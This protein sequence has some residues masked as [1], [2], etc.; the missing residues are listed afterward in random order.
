MTEATIDIN[1]VQHEGQAMTT[2]L[3][4]AQKF[5]KDHNYL[6]KKIKQIDEKSRKLGRVNFSQ[7]NYMNS[8]NK[9]MPM[10]LMN[11]EGFSI[12]AMGL[13]GDAAL[14]WKYKFYDAF[15]AMEQYIQ[16]FAGMNIEYL[17]TYHLLQDAVKELADRAHASGSKTPQSTF[18]M[19]FNKML[20][21]AID[22]QSGKRQQLPEALK[23]RLALLQNVANLVLQQ[24]IHLSHK[25]A[26]SKAKKEVMSY[27]QKLVEKEV[28]NQFMIH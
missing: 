27:Q 25:D 24:N 10:Y 18:H 8:Q 28:K 14:I 9:K 19:N 2:S 6:L 23:A 12:L 1:L 22:I 7:S 5:E 21:K 17:P 16:N 4:V 20:N 3:V 13:T 11:R 26:Y 15:E